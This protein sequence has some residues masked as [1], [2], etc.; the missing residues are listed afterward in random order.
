MIVHPATL[1]RAL[2]RK[3]KTGITDIE[4]DELALEKDVAA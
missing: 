3:T 2:L 1:V 4:D